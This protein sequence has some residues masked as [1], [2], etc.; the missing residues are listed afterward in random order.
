M[1]LVD[2][3]HGVPVID[4]FRVTPRHIIDNIADIHTTEADIVTWETFTKVTTHQFS[5]QDTIQQANLD[6]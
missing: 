3:L 4:K 5:N 6:R 1:T 2:E